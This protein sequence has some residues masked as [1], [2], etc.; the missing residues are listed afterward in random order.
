MTYNNDHIIV[1]RYFADEYATDITSADR[2]KK[3]IS[4]ANS[5]Y[6]PLV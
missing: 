2:V 1:S 5:N 4:L 3:L 6:P